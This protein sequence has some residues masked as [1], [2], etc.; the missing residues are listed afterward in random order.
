M[1]VNESGESVGSIPYASASLTALANDFLA[2]LNSDLA[3][4]DS[5]GLLILA[6]AALL[7]DEELPK[8]QYQTMMREI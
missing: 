2:L 8:G 7:F 3:A 4:A 6:V 5:F 1:I